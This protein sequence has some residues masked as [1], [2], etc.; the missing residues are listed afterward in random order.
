MARSY[1]ILVAEDNP[2]D[3]YLMREALREHGLDAKVQVVDNG[4]DAIRLVADPASEVPDL[5]LVDL[6]LPKRSG[7]EV[8]AAVRQ[9]D[10]ARRVLVVLLTSSESP[11]DKRL[12][13]QL[14]VDA[15]FHK[16]QGL[17]EFL[18]LGGLVKSLLEG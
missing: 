8:L 6:N 9:A 5:M 14:G 18:Q 1:S 2:G 11:K 3:V 16:P 10:S 4:D 12:A 7:H 17:D 13:E 15:W